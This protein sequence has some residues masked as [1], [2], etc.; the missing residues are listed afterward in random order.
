M[1]PEA[2]DII[3]LLEDVTVEPAWRI[4]PQTA[5][6]VLQCGLRGAVVHAHAGEPIYE[7]E[8]IDET[9]GKTLVLATLH[10]DQMRVVE[11]YTLLDEDE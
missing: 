8:F 5:P 1:E 11:R 6:A 10:A 3:E 9:T 7:V 4:N 2:F